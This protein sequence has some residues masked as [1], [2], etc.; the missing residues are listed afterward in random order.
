MSDVNKIEEVLVSVVKLG[1]LMVEVFKDGAQAEDVL[2][3]FE[4]LKSQ[5]EL[6][7]G[8]LDLYNSIDEI[9]A[10]AKDLD[11]GEAIDLAKVVIPEVIDLYKKIKA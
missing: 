2:V 8:L 11:L 10:E 7:K 6:S 4:K 1:G 5:P 9:K 3:I